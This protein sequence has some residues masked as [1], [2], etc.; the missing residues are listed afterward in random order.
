M[1]QTRDPVVTFSVKVDGRPLPLEVWLCLVHV[2]VDQRVRL[3]AM[4]SLAFHDPERKIL[5]EPMLAL[6]STLEVFAAQDVGKPVKLFDGEVTALEVEYDSGGMLSVVR[7]LDRSH[8]LTHGSRTRTFL[9]MTYADVVRKVGQEAG[10]RVEADATQPVL[11][12]VLQYNQSNLAFLHDL[13]AEVG[14]DLWVEGNTL[15]FKKPKPAVQAPAPGTVQASDPLQLVVGENL[16]S[17][18]ATATSTGQVAT[19]EV[20]GWDVKEKREIVVT[21]QRIAPQ[22]AS[23]GVPATQTTPSSGSRVAVSTPYGVH[24]EVETASEAFAQDLASSRIELEGVALGEPALQA[25]TTVSVGE[26]GERFNGR[27][28]VTAARHVFEPAEGYRTEFSVSG[29]ADRTLRGLVDGAVWRDQAGAHGSIDGVVPAIVTNN[30]DPLDLG[31]VKVKFPWL[32][33][34]HESAWA[35]PVQLIAGNGSGAAIIPEIN[36]EVLV[37]FEQGD[38]NRPYIIGSLYNGKDRPQKTTGQII[39]SDKVAQ[40]RIETPTLNRL[41]FFDEKGTKE[42][43]TLRTGDDKFFLDLDKTNTK[44]VLSSNGDVTI[45]AK[46]GKVTITSQNDMTFKSNNNLT[47]EGATK[48]TIKGA[49]VEVAAQGTMKLQANGPLEAK[50]AIIKLN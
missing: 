49:Q 37:A 3:P 36:D 28:T 17:L 12:Y 30:K 47:L 39:K 14:Y 6:G 35:R 9:N 29:R 4:A 42:G 21:K 45:E 26:A 19:A 1:P 13:A 32:T 18:R 2:V 23:N 40:R 41:V 15:K 43:I 16:R 44:V 50:G 38:P 33:D 20:R 25:G 11:E 10:L 46:T 7:G 27:Y 24:G 8:K 34:E 5:D 22:G 31:R 48:T